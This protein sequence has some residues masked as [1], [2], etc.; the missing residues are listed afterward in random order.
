MLMLCVTYDQ[1]ISKKK[2]KKN[3][4]SIGYFKHCLSAHSA[5][6]QMGMQQQR[7]K[8]FCKSSWDMT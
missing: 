2:R 1:K 7:T 5:F 6:H 8:Y 3:K 4:Q